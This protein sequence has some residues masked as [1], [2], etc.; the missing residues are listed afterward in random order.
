MKKRLRHLLIRS[1]VFS[2]LSLY[3]LASPQADV[4]A[5]EPK[6]SDKKYLISSSTLVKNVS[7]LCTENRPDPLEFPDGFGISNVSVA[8]ELAFPYDQGKSFKAA[9]EFAYGRQYAGISTV[10]EHEI[11]A[12]RKI[13]TPEGTLSFESVNENAS[14]L[15]ANAHLTETAAG[16]YAFLIS[17]ERKTASN[18]HILEEKYTTFLKQH[19]SEKFVEFL[20]NPDRVIQQNHNWD[21][22]GDYLDLYFKNLQGMSRFYSNY[23]ASN[24]FLFAVSISG[25]T[26][27][28]EFALR[29]PDQYA[30]DFLALFT[31]STD[32]N[33]FHPAVKWILRARVFSEREQRQIYSLGEYDFFYNGHLNIADNLYIYLLFSL[34]DRLNLN[35]HLQPE[36]VFDT[37]THIRSMERKFPNLSEIYKKYFKDLEERGVWELDPQKLKQHYI[38]VLKG[39][40]TPSYQNIEDRFLFSDILS[41]SRAPWNVKGT[42]LEKLFS[43]QNEYL[44]NVNK[45]FSNDLRNLSYKTNGTGKFKFSLEEQFSAFK[46]YGNSQ[47]S[48]KTLAPLQC[49]KMIVDPNI[50]EIGDYEF[51]IGVEEAVNHKPKLGFPQGNFC[52]PNKPMKKW[53]SEAGPKGAVYFFAWSICRLDQVAKFLSISED[54]FFQQIPRLMI[55][56]GPTGYHNFSNNKQFIISGGGL[57][58]HNAIATLKVPHVMR[59][60]A[61]DTSI[62]LQ[63]DRRGKTFFK[64]VS[65]LSTSPNIETNYEIYRDKRP[66]ANIYAQNGQFERALITIIDSLEKTIKDANQ[67]QLA[68]P[69]EQSLLP[70][71]RML[72]GVDLVRIKSLMKLI[73]FPESQVVAFTNEIIERLEWD[74]LDPKNYSNEFVPDLIPEV[75]MEMF[76]GY[77]KPEITIAQSILEERTHQNSKIIKRN[78]TEWIH[79]DVVALANAVG[80]PENKKKQFCN[81]EKIQKRI[82]SVSPET[83][84]LFGLKPRVNLPRFE[85]AAEI[86]LGDQ[87]LFYSFF[88]LYHECQKQ[89]LSS[90]IE[91]ARSGKITSENEHSKT[92]KAYANHYLGTVTNNWILKGI[93]VS[94]PRFLPA[95]AGLSRIGRIG[96]V[97][98]EHL[99]NA[100]ALTG[101]K[102]AFLNLSKSFVTRD[103]STLRAYQPQLESIIGN[104]ADI[105]LRKQG[106]VTED[107]TLWALLGTF[108]DMEASARV[109][110]TSSATRKRLIG[111]EGFSIVQAPKDG[112]LG[113]EYT[114]VEEELRNT[115]EE[116]LRYGA[117]IRSIS[118]GSPAA[119]SNIR[120]GD[121]IYEIDNKNIRE[122]ANGRKLI[123]SMNA[124]EVVEFKIFRNGQRLTK[125]ITIE[126]NKD[127]R[128]AASNRPQSSYILL[129]KHFDKM[130]KKLATSNNLGDFIIAKARFGEHS[131]KLLLKA[132]LGG[133]AKIFYRKKNEEHGLRHIT[134]N[135]DS[136]F[137][138]ASDYSP[139]GPTLETA[140]V[141]P[142]IVQKI[143]KLISVQRS[144][145]KSEIDQ[146]CEFFKPFW[147]KFNLPEEQIF[148]VTPSLNLMPI[149][150]E[151]ILGSGCK[152]EKH[153]FVIA[154]SFLAAVEFNEST[155][156]KNK[157]NVFVG[158]A[159]PLK[160]NNTFRIS[161]AGIKRSLSSLDVGNSQNLNLPPLPDASIEVTEIAK[162]FDQSHTFIDREASIRNVGHKLEELASAGSESLI[163]FATHG[164][165]GSND[166]QTALPALLSVENNEFEA[167]NSAE[168]NRFNIPNSTVLLSACDTASGI[169]NEPDKMFTG[170]VE[171]FANGGASL[172]LASLW[173]VGSSEAKSV[174]TSFVEEWKIS[175]LA[176]A[177]TKSK[178]PKSGLEA[179]L[180]F[181]YIAP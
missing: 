69:T 98:N 160:S 8:C 172:L 142:S 151:L 173:P 108:I 3:L 18:A 120:V 158:H 99:P 19:Y 148:T 135:Y 74:V 84:E 71:A 80:L 13:K 150:L 152:N 28:A 127:P 31:F 129:K 156:H 125:K 163:L 145:A 58:A 134:V 136:G 88:D 122:L 17:K 15:W 59:V 157:P 34:Q 174:T 121:L 49:R 1:L 138:T 78:A 161:L 37:L 102:H 109:I 47:T 75:T 162:L 38:A 118:S 144:I 137:I 110:I 41:T 92:L 140:Y 6:A 33:K 66:L 5:S 159:N 7:K 70:I 124:G 79:E 32:L 26:R 44:E 114:P 170:L 50:N 85:K 169:T 91:K 40:V 133:D 36:L 56:S 51:S 77:I 107:Q 87:S 68:N 89:F 153:K 29:I 62:H 119:K 20:L 64:S 22:F 67:D 180:P 94:D 53:I 100:F 73:G 139:K 132:F 25:K 178:E 4:R 106:K 113:V 117:V 181:V 90:I 141:A 164:L 2:L 61:D 30:S 147:S 112:W 42:D 72:V 93:D 9:I 63:S 143:Q 126:K 27:S 171:S 167:I 146:I 103:S 165:G 54:R 10:S 105:I 43:P 23:V 21:D 154:S 86:V 97:H 168:I 175:N 155:K 48:C 76:A 46:R 95:L 177:I 14:E 111:L 96:A 82:L 24:L 101:A 131:N 128:I 166:Q 81:D 149:P 179:V 12:F 65:D 39:S 116:D 16:L 123:P 115:L 60:P 176:K 55:G 52:K 83:E 35:A 104:A 45:I 57:I 130:N 11:L